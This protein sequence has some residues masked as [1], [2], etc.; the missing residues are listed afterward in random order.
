MSKRCNWLYWGLGKIW[1]WRELWGWLSNKSSYQVDEKDHLICT[2]HNVLTIML[3]NQCVYLMWV[4]KMVPAGVVTSC[5]M[6]QLNYA[7]E[8]FQYLQ[9]PYNMETVTILYDSLIRSFVW[10]IWWSKSPLKL[11]LKWF[12]GSIY[13]SH[14]QH[15]VHLCNVQA[16]YEFTLLWEMF[17]WVRAV[18]SLV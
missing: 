12:Y 8:Q 7:C 1:C 18:C 16:A 5:N 4:G 9:V 10:Y 15:L 13:K 14:W 3:T 11:H 2:P 17:T 6:H